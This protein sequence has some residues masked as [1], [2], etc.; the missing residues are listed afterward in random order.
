M[1]F[2]LSTNGPPINVSLSADSDDS[3]SL[4]PDGTGVVWE[5]CLGAN[6]GILRS[7]L[8]G[9]MWGAAEVVSDTPSNEGNPDTDGTWIVYDSNRLSATGG[10]I[11]FQP[12]MGGPETSPQLA[13]EQ[14]NP[15]IS[16]GVIAFESDPGTGFRPDI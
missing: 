15:S 6:C 16:S 12:L 10:D 4:S 1:V 13:G 8:S 2:D 7:V 9:G 3:P 14:R 11:Y 5:R